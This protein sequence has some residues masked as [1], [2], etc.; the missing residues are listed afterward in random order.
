MKSFARK[1]KLGDS[2][3]DIE[4]DVNTTRLS[5]AAQDEI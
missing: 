1:G 5:P 2:S 3:S 4:G